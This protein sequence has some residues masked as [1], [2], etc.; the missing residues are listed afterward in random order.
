MRDL[1]LERFI[2]SISYHDCLYMT[3]LQRKR[4]ISYRSSYD[5]AELLNDLEAYW[6]SLHLP[7]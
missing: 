3:I 2:L 1:H 4:D 7:C 5:A 6:I